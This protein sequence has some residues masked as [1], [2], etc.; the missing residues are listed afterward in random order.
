MLRTDDPGGTFLYLI[1]LAE[2]NIHHL[3]LSHMK[4]RVKTQL[5]AK[6]SEAT[7]ARKVNDNQNS[8]EAMGRATSS[9]LVRKQA[10]TH[11][12]FMEHVA[13]EIGGIVKFFLPSA[14]NSF[15]IRG[16]D[17]RQSHSN[18]SWAHLSNGTKHVPWCQLAAGTAGP[19]A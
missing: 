2:Q 18:L 5:G 13:Y 17:K 9:L 8:S 1:V 3:Q 19:P 4:I 14:Q 10:R 6:I 16:T 7:Q 12:I 11:D 15:H